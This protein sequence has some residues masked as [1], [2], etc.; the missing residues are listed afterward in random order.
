MSNFHKETKK[1]YNVTFSD[2]ESDEENK[3][4][5][6]NS[7]VALTTSFKEISNF[8]YPMMMLFLMIMVMSMMKMSYR[9]ILTEAHK[10]ILPEMN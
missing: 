4:D 10:T 3:Y 5:Q 9:M 2:D 1:D 7:V 8:S 6:T